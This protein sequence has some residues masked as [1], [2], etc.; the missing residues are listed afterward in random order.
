MYEDYEEIH[1]IDFS[2]PFV[3]MK[4]IIYVGHYV[5]CDKCSLV[6]PAYIDMSGVS[7]DKVTSQPCPICKRFT[8]EIITYSEENPNIGIEEY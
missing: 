8:L 6:S 7:E 2:F 3:L 4:G 1:A 5:K